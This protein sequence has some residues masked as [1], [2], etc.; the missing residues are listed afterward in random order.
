MLGRGQG[1]NFL[2]RSG[3][4]RIGSV[5]SCMLGPSLVIG[6]R[7]GGVKTANDCRPTCFALAEAY[8]NRQVYESRG[9]ATPP[10]ALCLSVG[11]WGEAAVLRR[12]GGAPAPPRRLRSRFWRLRH[13]TRGDGGGKY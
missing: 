9:G 4:Q 7:R 6:R 10:P 11:S 12:G 1:G 2:E 3:R 13:A 8:G 5:P